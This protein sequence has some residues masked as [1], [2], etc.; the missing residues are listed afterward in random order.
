MVLSQAPEMSRSSWLHIVHTHPCTGNGHKH[1]QVSYIKILYSRNAQR[2]SEKIQQSFIAKNLPNLFWVKIRE[3]ARAQSSSRFKTQRTPNSVVLLS[4]LGKGLFSQDFQFVSG[5][6]NYKF[7]LSAFIFSTSGV[8]IL[9]AS[10]D[11]SSCICR[12]EN[13]TE[14]TSQG[15]GKNFSF[16]IIKCWVNIY[17]SLL[18]L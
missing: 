18:S 12:S 5:I 6:I 13:N 15:E 14:K 10:L 4:R 17:L 2:I 1:W 11:P 16:P 3:K 8:K 7:G 9:N